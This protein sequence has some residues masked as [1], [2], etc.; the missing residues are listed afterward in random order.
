MIPVA[1]RPFLEHQFRLLCSQGLTDIL[2]CVG[3]LGE[4]IQEHFR[5]GAEFG[6]NITYSWEKDRLLGTA[7]CLKN[8]EPFLKDEFIVTYGDAY[9]LLD[10][11]DVIHAHQRSSCEGTMVV[12]RNENR[13]DRSNVIVND[14]KV[15]FY[16]KVED[17]PG[18]VYIDYGVTVLHRDSLR[19]VPSGSPCGL[20][21][22]HQSLI[23]VEQLH[24]YE[25]SQRFYEI[26]SLS[27]LTELQ[28]LLER[29]KSAG[30]G[31]TN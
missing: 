18:M 28:Q 25:T 3:Y 5:D 17:R 23:Q 10:Y 27:G 1:G 26:G 2:L 4:Q 21:V 8:A 9:L 14:N 19:F 16:S 13:Y 22:V 31:G 12:Y 20:E 30:I 24:A 29:Q 6:M 15:S 7:G 11:Q